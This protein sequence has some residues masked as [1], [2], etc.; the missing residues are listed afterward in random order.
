M[1]PPPLSIGTVLAIAQCM[2]RYG[3][4]NAVARGA[5]TVAAL[6][7]TEHAVAKHGPGDGRVVAVARVMPRVCSQ[8]FTV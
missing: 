1:V 2:P 4:V 8:L 6:H 3:T 7:G 5:R